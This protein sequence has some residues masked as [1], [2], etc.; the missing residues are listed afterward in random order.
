MC[1]DGDGDGGTRGFPQVRQFVELC[2][3][4]SYVGRIPTKLPPCTEGCTVQ[5]DGMQV[6]E[7][8][9]LDC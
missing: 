8:D 5:D 2:R 3:W 9:D 7:S 6:A 1:D 4:R